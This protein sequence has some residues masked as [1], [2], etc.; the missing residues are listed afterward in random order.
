MSSIFDELPS[1]ADV[2]QLQQLQWTRT[3]KHHLTD[4]ESLR[5]NDELSC[6]SNQLQHSSGIAQRIPPWACGYRPTNHRGAFPPHDAMQI[7]KINTPFL[8]LV[9]VLAPIFPLMT[10]A[11]RT[12]SVMKYEPGYMKMAIHVL[13]HSPPLLILLIQNFARSASSF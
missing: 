5:R 7:C 1:K 8:C 9:H 11:F 12:T 6:P 10:F 2:K 13:R 3:T 4:S